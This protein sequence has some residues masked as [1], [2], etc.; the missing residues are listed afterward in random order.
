[1][2]SA[3]TQPCWQG[4]PR[5][6]Q[7]VHPRHGV[8]WYARLRPCLD[9]VPVPRGPLVAVEGTGARVTEPKEKA[10]RQRASRWSPREGGGGGEVCGCNA[11]VMRSPG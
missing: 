6:P 10:A 11:T 8:G 7:A 2:L 5:A 1:M 3:R 9:V 4:T